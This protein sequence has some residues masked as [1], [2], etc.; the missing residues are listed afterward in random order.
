[1]LSYDVNFT[2]T[3]QGVVIVYADT[4]R[5]GTIRNDPATGEKT[6][7][8]A[9]RNGERW[10][11]VTGLFHHHVE[12]A[13]VVREIANE[14][15]ACHEAPTVTPNAALVEALGVMTELFDHAGLFGLIAYHGK[16]YGWTDSD[17]QNRINACATA[18][19]ALEKAK[20]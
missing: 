2:N 5:I 4:R 8:I 7:H 16:E 17:L 19:A 14:T 12:L 6:L 3:A 9:G 20:L 18:R 1:M 15:E 10:H 11:N 13:E